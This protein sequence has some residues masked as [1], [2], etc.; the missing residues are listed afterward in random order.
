MHSYTVRSVARDQSGFLKQETDR[1]KSFALAFA[2]RIHEL[3]EYGRPLNLEKNFVV[4]VRDSYVDIFWLR[5]IF[6]SLDVGPMF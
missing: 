6:G 4:V 1:T 5:P 2:E 3:L